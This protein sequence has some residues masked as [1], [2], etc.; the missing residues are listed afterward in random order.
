MAMPPNNNV[1]ASRWKVSMVGN[2]RGEL[3][4]ASATK[5]SSHHRKNGRNNDLRSNSYNKWYAV[6]LPN[7]MTAIHKIMENNP[8]NFTFSGIAGALSQV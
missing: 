2:A 4:R 5:V 8:A 7:V 1:K 6:A 3:R